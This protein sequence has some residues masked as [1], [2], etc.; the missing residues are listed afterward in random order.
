MRWGIAWFNDCTLGTK[1]RLCNR[2]LVDEAR[3]LAFNHQFLSDRLRTRLEAK[4]E[5]GESYIQ[6]LRE[7]VDHV[8]EHVTPM[9]TALDTELADC[10]VESDS[11]LHDVFEGARKRFEKSVAT[12]RKGLDTAQATTAG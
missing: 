3:H 12:A 7:R 11:V 8:L 10:G 9:F 4:G 1:Q 5:D 2:I 6:S